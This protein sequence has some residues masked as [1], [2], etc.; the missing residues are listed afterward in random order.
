MSAKVKGD[1]ID[2]SD[3]SDEINKFERELID[4]AAEHVKKIEPFS[5]LLQEVGG[6]TNLGWAFNPRRDKMP[7]AVADALLRKRL[8]DVSNG[9]RQK[10]VPLVLRG[11][12]V[13]R[14]S[15]LA[16][17]ALVVGC[18]RLNENFELWK[19]LAKKDYTAAFDA[20]MITEWPTAADSMARKRVPRLALILF[21]GQIPA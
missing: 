12:D 11:L 10:L 14:A 9:L 17:M 16:H 19:A 2:S 13:V 18:D 8:E 3:A 5:E 21:T 20:F 7:K 15:A 1:N 6:I 4:T